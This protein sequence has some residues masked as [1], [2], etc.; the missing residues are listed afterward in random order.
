MNK[1]ALGPML[2]LF[3]SGSAMAETLSRDRASSI[4]G[5]LLSDPKNNPPLRDNLWSFFTPVDVRFEA[6]TR[7]CPPPPLPGYQNY[8]TPEYIKQEQYCDIRFF[9]RVTSSLLFFLEAFVIR[10]WSATHRS[11]RLSSSSSCAWE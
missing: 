5:S 3:A 11:V 10:R 9:S 8:K 4:I 7:S 6:S 2:I 1:L